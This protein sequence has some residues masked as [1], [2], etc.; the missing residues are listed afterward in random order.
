MIWFVVALVSP[1]SSGSTGPATADAAR[2]AT[3]TSAPAPTTTPPTTTP[4][5]SPTATTPSPAPTTPE[6]TTPAPT[7]TKPVRATASPSQSEGGSGSASGSDTGGDTYYANC[8]EARAAGAAPIYA[9]Q[10]GY[11]RRL[12][13]DG[14]GI[15][16][17]T[18]GGSSSSSSSSTSGGSSSSSGG[19]DSSGD[20]YYANCTEARAAGAAP[21]Y[22]GQPGYS[23]RLDRDG[24]GV[25][26]E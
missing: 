20:T 13:R 7:T 6:P 4:A 24:D 15:A 8:T 2:V 17:E 21:I 3:T 26:C 5:P 1:G 25:A 11:S 16:C 19:S 12:D 23:R 10:P 9:G 14:D 22:A 18:G